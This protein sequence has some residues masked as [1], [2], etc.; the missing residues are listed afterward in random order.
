MAVSTPITS[1]NAYGLQPIPT[2]P[3]YAQGAMMSGPVP[4]TNYA[5]GDIM[6]AIREVQ[7][8]P[9]GFSAEEIARAREL[10]M[11]YLGKDIDFPDSVTRTLGNAAFDFVDSLAFGLIPDKIGPHKLTSADDIAGM[12]GSTAALFTPGIGP[13][14]VGTKIAKKI[15]PSVAKMGGGAIA[16][17]GKVAGEGAGAAAVEGIGK[18]AGKIAEWLKSPMAAARLGSAIGGGFNFEDGINPMGAVLGALF[19]MGAGKGVA[20]AADDA[21][22]VASKLG[23]ISALD[24]WMNG[25]V[26]SEMATKTTKFGGFSD[27]VSDIAKNFGV[28]K[29]DVMKSYAKARSTAL[30]EASDLASKAAAEQKAA[31]L[32]MDKVMR[33]K[34]ARV[35][36]LQTP[37][38]GAGDLRTVEFDEGMVPKALQENWGLT[39]NNRVIPQYRGTEIPS[40]TP[41]PKQPIYKPQASSSVSQNMDNATN[42]AATPSAISTLPAVTL[43]KTS[44]SVIIQPIN[45]VAAESQDKMIKIISAKTG[46]PIKDV[47]YV[48]EEMSKTATATFDDVLQYLLSLGK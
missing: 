13:M 14:A 27:E 40:V 43:A 7:R 18:G 17:V 15:L 47:Q 44:N 16:N 6:N 34:A 24:E 45:K 37:I 12:V 46:I 29:D 31:S 19:P 9:S 11:Q 1:Y 28:S 41:A 35:N 30:K 36:G 21:A 23:G 4:Q 26:K 48:V 42:A 3:V 20:N 5:I 32:E 39:S 10:S 22:N 8:N 33:E 2:N 25:L 38:S